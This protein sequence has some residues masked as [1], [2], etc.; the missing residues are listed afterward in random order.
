MAGLGHLFN[1]AIFS[2]NE[3]STANTTADNMQVIWVA[4][5]DSNYD[6]QGPTDITCPPGILYKWNG[7]S[8][9]EITTQSTANGGNFG[10]F[11][12]QFAIDYNALTGK[13]VVLVNSARGGSR[14]YPN[15]VDP[16]DWYTTGGIMRAQAT[17]QIDACLQYLGLEEPIA[18]FGNAMINDIRAGTSISNI[19]LAFDSAVSY[20]TGK[21]PGVPFLYSIPGHD[22][23]NVN[24][25]INRQCRNLI[26]QKQ[27]TV[28]EF[29]IDSTCAVFYSLGWGTL[30]YNTQDAYN[31]LGA[32]K[33][34]WFANPTRSKYARSI[35]SMHFGAL[36]E[37]RKDLIE[38]EIIAFGNQLF[39]DFEYLYHFKVSDVKDT[40]ID[41]C[42][43]T[44]PLATDTTFTANSHISHSG[45]TTSYYRTFFTPSTNQTRVSQTDMFHA[46]WVKVITSDATTIRSAFGASNAAAQFTVGHTTTGVFYRCNDN[47]L[48]IARTG[49]LASNTL[50]SGVRNG[51]SKALWENGVQT[52]TV[53]VASTGTID[54]NIIVGGRNSGANSNPTI[55]ESQG[56]CGGKASTIN[57]ATLYSI[58]NTR[59][60]GW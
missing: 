25:L 21:F 56:I 22:E 13:K 48:T 35:I 10:A 46:E 51:T 50:L 58:W 41:Y 45:S 16:Y 30:H 19:S 44:A 6:G 28:S 53:V 7:V 8:L 54:Q 29:A 4:F 26:V 32:C 1:S 3:E 24:A 39:E 18:T 34:R 47:T 17:A 27:R 60:S 36:T 14:L 40:Y 38:N 5:A 31:H 15:G 42:L 23:T 37:A 9:T 55:G 12:K 20:V 57:Q 43:L 49:V 59:D 2:Q 33:A 11:H 52:H